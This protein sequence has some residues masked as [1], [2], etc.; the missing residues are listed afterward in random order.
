MLLTITCPNTYTNKNTLIK[1]IH[2]MK[3]QQELVQ[4]SFKDLHARVAKVNMLFR[5]AVLFSLKR[6]STCQTCNMQKAMKIDLRVLTKKEREVNEMTYLV[7][8]NFH[9]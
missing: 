9:Q 5:T 1:L 6:K 4:L 2:I 7:Q 8:Q 3:V